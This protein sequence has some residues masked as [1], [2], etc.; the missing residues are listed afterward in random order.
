MEPETPEGDAVASELNGTNGHG[1]N[2]RAPARGDSPPPALRRAR[3]A[4]LPDLR[5][6]KIA[7]P[8]V[9]VLAFGSHSFRY[10]WAADATPRKVL[11]VV[12]FP[13][14]PGANP[15]KPP[16]VPVWAPRTTAASAEAR[17]TF[18]KEKEELAEALDLGSRRIGGGKPVPWAVEVEPVAAGAEATPAAADTKPELSASAPLVGRAAAS[19]LRD[20]RAAAQYDIVAPMWDGRLVLGTSSASDGMVRSSLDALLRHIADELGAARER[21]SADGTDES[22]FAH[23]HIAIVLPDAAERR[24]A[25]EL[26]EAVFRVDALRAGAVFL[27]QS[28]VSCALGAGIGNCAVIDIGHC[29]TTIACVEDGVMVG[30][31]RVHLAYGAHAMRAAFATLLRGEAAFDRAMRRVLGA[32]RPEADG[33]PDGES[34]KDVATSSFAYDVDEVAARAFEQLC[35]FRAED[36]DRVRI[37]SVTLPDGRPLRV[38]LGVGFLALPAHGLTRPSLLMSGSAAAGCAVK[39]RARAVHERSGDNDAFLEEMYAD[40]R[41]SATATAALPIGRF[42]NEPGRAKDGAPAEDSSIVDALVWAIAAAVRVSP[43]VAQKP[44]AAAEVTKKFYRH[45]VLSGGGASVEGI[46][47]A[48]ESKIKERLSEMGEAV[49]DV[50]I[51][52]GGKGKGDEELAAAKAV[53]RDQK[54]TAGAADDT[55]TASLPW[56]GSAVMIEADAVQ[57][58]WVY[59]DEWDERSVR[60]TRERV[61]FYW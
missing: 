36:N 20:P 12:A 10:G 11:S 3:R 49:Y 60:V 51:I 24:D 22:S 55:D 40:V 16:L 8:E 7:A 57:G 5:A 58:F 53:L 41:R 37:A 6:E 42:P 52:D 43:A 13:R 46:A 47:L 45:I 19:L 56:K 31:S 54:T 14:K 33:A 2:G 30:D 59:K 39:L 34:T 21:S 18:I 50:T 38:K 23:R 32:E 9:I 61:P 1:S 44:N 4:Q 48:L 26:V 25:T 17:V 15:T 27:H 35:R 29:A 28:S